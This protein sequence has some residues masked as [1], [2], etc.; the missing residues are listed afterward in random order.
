MA[1][2]V[3]A[4]GEDRV[5]P[6]GPGPE[7]LSFARDVRPILA[8]NCFK[9]HGPDPEARQ[10]DLRLD[11]REGAL[12][13]L[14]EGGAAVIP[15]DSARSK[16]IERVTSADLQERM[17]PVEVNR[18]GLKRDDIE[19]LR[20]WID[21]G[22]PWGQHWS[23]VAPVKKPLPKVADQSWCR[24]GLDSWVAARLEKEGIKPSPEASRATLI[25]RVS[26]D[27]TGLP[28]TPGEVDAFAGDSSADAYKKV[29][30][31]LL[32]SPRFGEKWA[33][34]WLDLARYADTKG[35]EKD[36]RRTMWPYRD[37]VIRSL[38]ADM[39][40]SEF[41]VEQLAGDMLPNATQDQTIATAFHR[42]TMTN[43]EGGTDDE[44]FR[45]AAVID[46]VNT[47]MEVWQGLTMGCAQ[48]HTHKYDPIKQTD[49]YRMFAFFNNTEDA[50][51]DPETP[52]LRIMSEDDRKKLDGVTARIAAI[53]A[54]VS[55]AVADVDPAAYL[56][57]A[58]ALPVDGTEADSIWI[59]DALPARAVPHVENLGPAWPW[60]VSPSL[61]EGTGGKADA[62]APEHGELCFGGAA[63][64][65][66]QQFVTDAAPTLG[67]GPGDK[68][69]AHVYLDPKNPPKEIMLQW[70]TT[71][72]QWEQ[73]AYWGENQLGYGKNGTESRRRRGD[74][75]E[76]GKWVRL[77]V[78]AKAVG[79]EGRHVDGW[80]FS[81]FDGAAY[82]DHAGVRSTHP[83][84]LRYTESLRSWVALERA[85][86]TKGLPGPV[87]AAVMH[88]DADRTPEEEA[89]LRE[90]YLRNIHAPTRDKVAAVET[91]AIVL[92]DEQQRLENGAPMLPVMHEL[93]GDKRRVTHRF[94]RGSFLNPAEEVQPGVP[95]A[96]GSAPES[97][98]TNRLELAGW[99]MSEHNP[100]TARVI[101]N[102]VWEQLWGTG[103]VETVEDF[104]TQ[105]FWPTDQDLLDHLAVEF[106]DRQAWSLKGL[107]RYI[108]TSAAYRQSSGA[109]AELLARDP[110]N[111]LLAR[112]PR[113]R[114]DG[115]TIRDQALAAGGL[116]SAKMYGPPVFPPQPD[117]LWIMIYSNDKWDTS[118]GE[119]K[120]RRALYTFWRRTVP[121]PAMTTFDAP[122]RE[123]CV[124]RRIR[125]NTPLQS[126]VTLNDPAFVE[127]A[128]A[129][130]RRVLKDGGVDDRSRAAYAFK[131]A[132]ARTPSDAEA[133][134]VV[135]LL[136][137]E[138]D[139][140]RA[141][142]AAAQQAATS[143]L[144]PLP[145]GV[146]R[147]EAAAWSTV[148]SVILNLDETLTKE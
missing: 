36:S 111:R 60:V 144:G 90:Y 21:E 20:R 105:G 141:D 114:L 147:V 46:R 75:P 49:Y 73:R 9:C 126:F 143:P 28:P 137:G 139:R 118:K 15:K 81:Q 54:R 27:L 45:V 56:R 104:G 44:E 38:N 96:F 132:A 34:W 131:L 40:F 80:A 123:F 103:I 63:G 7:P 78:D 74:L 108:V 12:A 72:K 100:L 59:D 98:P 116:L 145:A 17:P 115:E 57:E 69:F 31:R 124:S 16:L 5:P 23:F 43:D 62:P 47:T 29:V 120:Y 14:K 19:A 127:C 41:T 55:K 76:P 107:L 130:A 91:E 77:E 22:A 135:R 25:R 6:A 51:A 93:Q 106:R 53:D 102:R 67:I 83:V 84:D 89:A 24:N 121:H 86:P 39:P 65:A 113:F 95:D 82:W 148:C 32:A 129:M 68:L 10:A 4:T 128:Q 37:W 50:D 142:A 134:E 11:T 64:G 13:A 66:A 117:G 3:L 92:K 42:N 52:F 99:L 146:D 26:L 110:Y 1:V 2:G 112:G 88:D 48:C 94:I 136:T 85:Q 122:S 101:V 109:S 97:A 125:T 8:A 119:D 79:L 58:P 33:R 140:F 133:A 30:D 70:H 35:Y 138:R 61:R 18:H 87:A 71:E